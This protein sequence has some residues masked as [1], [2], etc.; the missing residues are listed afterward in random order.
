MKQ[1]KPSFAIALKLALCFFS[2]SLY[3]FSM[4]QNPVGIFDDYADIG[5]PKIKGSSN[6]DEASQ[7]Y[8][9]SGAGYNIW[10]NRDEFQYLYKKIKGDFILTADFAF[11]GNAD[12]GNNHSKIGWMVRESKDE[13]A[14]SIN[15]TYH[16][17]GLMV[18]Q[19]RK[20]RGM[21]MRDP[22]DEIFYPKKGGQTIQLSRAGNT[23]TMKLANYGEP[24]QVVGSYELKELKDEVLAG[25]FI[26]SHDSTKLATAKVWN[27]RIDKPVF[28][29]Y[30]SNPNV[31]VKEP[32]EI[33]GC[34][35]ELLDIAD[36][37]RKVI[38][39]SKQRF[40][41]PNWLP[42]GNSLLFNSSGNIYTI[43]IAGGNPVQLN[44]GAIKRN[45]NDHVISFDGKMLAISSHRDGLPGGGSTVYTLPITGGEPKQLTQETPSY[46]HG[47]NPNGKEVVIVAQR[48]GSNVYNLYKVA[49]KDAKETAIT[50]NTKGHV[51]GPEY[52]P[53]GKYIYYNANESGTM[54]IWRVKA[55][56][57]EKEQLTFDE[58]HNWFPH[59]SPDGKLLVMISFPPDIDPN[60][61]PSYKNVMLRVLKLDGAGAPKVVAHLFG[62]QGTINVPSWSPDSKR[63]AFVSN[64]EKTN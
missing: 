63:I 44:T 55:D 58:Y 10:F 1:Q 37:K 39:E 59:I 16:Y 12:A 4:A 30:T 3:S 18:L 13:N 62:G 43:P 36:G 23:V 5:N 25:L 29:P 33:F 20:Y 14:A 6:Y 26:C 32:A 40:E 64:S 34:R 42:D 60:S 38:Y 17:D 31:K 51:D 35:L 28:Y 9:I 50:T 53:D 45:N 21:F 49:L 2:L 19:W 57:T 41:A 47:W 54:Q 46:L 27:V 56:G 11:T 15:G 24:L 8:N 22:E 7:T 61:H 52:S 48:G